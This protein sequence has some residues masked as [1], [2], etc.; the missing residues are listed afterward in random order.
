MN[1][2]RLMAAVLCGAM[3]LSM[4]GFA[5]AGDGWFDS[6]STS[7]GW[8]GTSSKPA[9]NGVT[10]SGA[11]KSW[12]PSWT[13]SK[14]KPKAKSNKSM[15]NSMTTGTKNTWNKTTSFLNP[16]DNPPKPSTSSKETAANS[17]GWFTSKKTEPKPPSTIGDFMVQEKPKW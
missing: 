3:W 7:D 5:S 1:L 14:P 6:A 2:R 17:S 4:I 11:K 15:W 13:S 16:F 8:F 10:T 12:W 9:A